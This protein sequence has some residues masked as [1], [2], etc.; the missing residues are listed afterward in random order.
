[1]TGPEHIQICRSRS[2]AQRPSA[3]ACAL[4]LSLSIDGCALPR[5]SLQAPPPTASEQ[6]RLE[7]YE[8]LRPV[9]L[10]D[11]EIRTY[12]TNLSLSQLHLANN[13]VISDPRDLI[14][15]VP[16]ESSTATAARKWRKHRTRSIWWD[17]TTSV[18]GAFSTFSLYGTFFAEK[19]S[20]RKIWLGTGIAAGL[21][22]ITS[23]FLAQR[24]ARLANIQR[25]HAFTYYNLDLL[26]RLDLQKAPQDPKLQDRSFRDK[27]DIVLLPRPV[28]DMRRSSF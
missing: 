22:G 18:S 2:A 17:I 12:N 15:V 9:S 26:K 6:E 10:N 5:V 20:S 25:S 23:Y 4:L 28:P 13:R 1:M 11:Y 3:A 19:P 14:P 8:S 7:A 24:S 16:P 21:F 27:S